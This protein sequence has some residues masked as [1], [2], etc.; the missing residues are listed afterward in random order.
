MCFW[1]SKIFM[2][3]EGG[4]V[5]A[6]ILFFL[7]YLLADR[8]SYYLYVAL[9]NLATIP[10][11]SAFYSTELLG[12]TTMS[13]VPGK[14]AAGGICSFISIVTSIFIILLRI[15]MNYF[16]QVFCITN[17]QKNNI[18]PEFPFYFLK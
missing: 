18:S 15:F 4:M 1:I 2:F 9:L 17:I 12:F 16:W 11:I 6:F 7:L 13:Y 3:F 5:C 8:K 10:F 14:M